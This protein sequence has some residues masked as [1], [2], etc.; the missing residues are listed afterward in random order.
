MQWCTTSP[1]DAVQWLLIGVLSVLG[2][3]IR[4][5][6]ACSCAGRATG[7]CSVGEIMGMR[8]G[9]RPVRAR[10]PDILSGTASGRW[11]ST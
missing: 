2:Y 11:Q 4:E 10:V 1:I 6:L 5:R 3:I 8:P 7:D 9:M